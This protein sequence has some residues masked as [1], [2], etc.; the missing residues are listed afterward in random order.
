MLLRLLHH[1]NQAHP[2][3]HNDAYAPLVVL[4]ARRVR[5]AGGTS[6]LDIGCGTGN[7]VARLAR[8][9]PDV[10][11][12]EADKRTADLAA[13]ATVH[14]AAVRVQH[15]LFPRPEARR[16]DLVSMVAVLHHMPLIEG[17][18]AARQAVAPGGRLIIVGTYRETSADWPL[19]LLSLVLNPLIGVVLHPRAVSRVP[20]HM[21]APVASA[22]DS[23]RDIACALRTELPG[24]SVHRGMFWRYVATWRVP[25]DRDD[26]QDNDRSAVRQSGRAI[27]PEG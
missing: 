5:R 4:A 15:A 2:W 24:V 22:A 20:Q 19:S 17:I 12:L 21:T 11:G 1:V 27:P 6:A 3:S 26:A 18:R 8:E 16:F 10:I 23:Y 9:L 25:R 13:A 7:L 14:L